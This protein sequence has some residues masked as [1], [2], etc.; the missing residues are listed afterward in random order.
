M[1]TVSSSGMPGKRTSLRPLVWLVLVGAIIVGCS[2][3]EPRGG[4]VLVVG[5]DGASNVFIEPMLERG[6][7]P[8]LASLRRDG[9][10]GAM[11]PVG[12]LLSPRIWTSMATGKLPENHGIEN[13]VW[14]DDQQRPRLFSSRDRNG[15]ALWNIVG[16]AGLEVAV[17]NWLVTHP[18][19]KIHGVMISDH[20]L[21][22]FSRGQLRLAGQMAAKYTGEPQPQV[23]RYGAD[24][25]SVYPPEWIARAAAAR[26]DTARLTDIENPFGPGDDL[27]NEALRALTDLLWNS[28]E[29]DGAVTRMALEVARERDPDLMM[30]YL[31]GVDRVS[32]LLWPSRLYFDE[33]RPPAA[34]E[35]NRDRVHF[36]WLRTYYR[37]A[38]ALLGRIMAHYG[39]D[40]LVVVVSDHGFERNTP[41]AWPTGMHESEAARDG[42]LYARGPHVEQSAAGVRLFMHDLTPSVLAWLGLPVAEN[43]SGN[44]AGFL[45]VTE[46]ERISTYDD[47]PIERIESTA[48]GERKRI[49]ELRLLGYVD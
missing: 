11:R 41:G 10:S 22:T 23:E 20:V 7:L 38:D 32:H 19:E 15:H 36:E 43:M 26:N 8:A 30:V 31:P 9:I 35:E 24:A 34:E 27:G 21:P 44:V 2:R 45:R 33:P 48:A 3:T 40:D 13:W 14:F 39:P 5:I 6:E 4:R 16:D 17:V 49:E 25:S 1:P 37:Y 12:G 42:I 29:N 46:A 28:F 18:P 47:R